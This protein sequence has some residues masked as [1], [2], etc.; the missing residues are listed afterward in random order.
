MVK[1]KNHTARNQT[2]KAHRNGIK[3][4]KKQMFQSTKG[5]DPKF[6]RNQRFA[7]KNNKAGQRKAKKE[8]RYVPQAKK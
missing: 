5:V 4:P 6:V 8:G 7:K 3:R 2:Y 1:Q